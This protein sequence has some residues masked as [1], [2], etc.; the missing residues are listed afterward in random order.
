MKERSSFRYPC[1]Q[2]VECIDNFA[3]NPERFTT[4]VPPNFTHIRS[5][6]PQ[7]GTSSLGAPSSLLLSAIN[8]NACLFNNC[9]CAY[10]RQKQL[11]TRSR[12][13]NE[14]CQLRCNLV[15]KFLTMAGRDIL[16]STSMWA[17]FVNHA[18]HSSAQ[19]RGMTRHRPSISSPG[20]GS[21]FPS[22]CSRS[23]WWKKQIIIRT[24]LHIKID[25]LNNELPFLVL[26]ALLIGPGIGPSNHA[27]ATFA[28]DIADT[29]EPRDQHAVLGLSDCDV[30]TMVK[31]ISATCDVMV[32]KRESMSKTNYNQR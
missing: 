23:R 14:C 12:L 13:S 2:I 8:E 4:N 7:N 24:F 17:I 16:K 5:T 11:E 6:T 19:W 9:C 29:V 25:F 28:K 27:L 32:R 18:C 20:H 3:K 31:E 26:L 1:A 21:S 10:A 30:N 22:V 15:D